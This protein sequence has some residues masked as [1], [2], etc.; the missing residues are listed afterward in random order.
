MPAY[1]NYTRWRL[2]SSSSC[3]SIR[4][5][6]QT[7]NLVF[8]AFETRRMFANGDLLT[9]FADDGVLQD[10]IVRRTNPR[11]TVT[12]AVPLADG[13]LVVGGYIS[14]SNI[15]IRKT[16]AVRQTSFI[17]KFLSNGELDRSFGENGRAFIPFPSGAGRLT[18]LR[19]EPKG[20]YIFAISS[21]DQLNQA[22]NHEWLALGR[23]DD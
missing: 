8:E 12:S 21:I 1:R 11:E 9:S 5:M 13:G 16:D 22:N 23:I 3:M 18:A 4:N 20:G 7:R 19:Q 17:A 15:G 10:G 6:V 14:A 2:C